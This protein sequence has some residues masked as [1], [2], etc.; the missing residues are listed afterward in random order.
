MSSAPEAEV[1]AASREHP[2]ETTARSLTVVPVIHSEQDL[3]SFAEETRI[4][5][6]AALGPAA[7]AQRAAA[8]SSWWSGLSACVSQLPLDWHHTRLYQDGLPV[9]EHELVIVKELAHKGNPNHMLLLSLVERGATLMGTEDAALI[10]REYRRIQR[11]V[12]GMRAG[13]KDVEEVRREGESLLQERDAFIASRI[14]R[15]LQAGESA[16]LFIGVLH[17]VEPHLRGRMNVRPL[18]YKLPAGADLSRKGK[19]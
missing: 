2:A 18:H 19:G 16:V 11:L 1:D 9:C 17:R 13:D 12:Q 7:A 6:A 5:M 8:I 15:T 4:R 3:G 14:D 10:V